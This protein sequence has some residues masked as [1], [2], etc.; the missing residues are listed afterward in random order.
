M[1]SEDT[2]FA[3]P[4]W[5]SRVGTVIVAR[6]D[7]QSLDVR[8]F[9]GIWMY[10]DMILN[11]FRDGDVTGATLR[12]DGR[13]T[14]KDFEKWWE[15]YAEECKQIRGEYM[16]MN[17]VTVEKGGPDDWSSVPPLF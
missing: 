16:A 9:E 13:Y 4:E 6:K 5:Q 7:K 8:H 11:S 15:G 12:R 10:I 2:G 3:P 1:I 14:K 17:G